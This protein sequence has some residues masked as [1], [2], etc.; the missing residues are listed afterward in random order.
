MLFLTLWPNV[1]PY[2]THLS[3]FRFSSTVWAPGPSSCCWLDDPPGLT[4]P[5][6]Q[7]EERPSLVTRTL[8]VAGG[9]CLCVPCWLAWASTSCSSL[10][11]RV[12]SASRGQGFFWMN[13]GKNFEKQPWMK[14]LLVLPWSWHPYVSPWCQNT[15]SREMQSGLESWLG[16]WHYLR[17]NFPHVWREDNNS[18][19]LRG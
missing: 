18:A 13:L 17:P 2:L 19:F 6:S 8:C 16:C 3:T 9:R 11:M 1:W 12:R 15:G 4:H 14:E 5:T 10:W 7:L